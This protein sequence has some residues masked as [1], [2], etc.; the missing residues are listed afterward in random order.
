M[1]ILPTAFE[2]GFALQSKTQPEPTNLLN[3]FWTEIPAIGVQK[4]S[5]FFFWME[6]C[7]NNFPTGMGAA[8][9]GLPQRVQLP[10]GF[11]G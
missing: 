6:A 10:R 5:S 7:R 9:S 4:V 2:R 8:W 3:A 11:R 1:G